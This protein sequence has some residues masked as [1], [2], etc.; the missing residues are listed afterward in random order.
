MAVDFM[1]GC[2]GDGGG[3]GGIPEGSVEE[4]AQA[5]FRSMEK[6]LRLLSHQSP[7]KRL[8]EQGPAVAVAAECRG[9]VAK[10]RKVISLLDHA[11]TGHARFRRAPALPHQMKRLAGEEA[12]PATAEAKKRKKEDE[13]GSLRRLPPLPHIHQNHHLLQRHRFSTAD[14]AAPLTTAPRAAAGQPPGSSSFSL[15]LKRSFGTSSEGAA[16]PGKCHCP[17]KR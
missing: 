11:R 14:P 9:A 17:R 15:P 1:M 4:A 3:E 8:E 2:E 12:A 7:E 5:G 16:G 6:L 10:F 13:E